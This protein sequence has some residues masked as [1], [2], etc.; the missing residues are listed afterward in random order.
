MKVDR[1]VLKTEH[2][3]EE[4]LLQLMQGK[5]IDQ[6]TTTEVCRTASINRNTFYAHYSTPTSLLDHIVEQFI[7]ILV[8][9]I[10]DAV[11]YNNNTELVEHILNDLL[12][13]QALASVILSDD[14]DPVY[15]NR[16]ISAIRGPLISYWTQSGTSIS[17]NE[18]STL[19]T[20][21]SFGANQL[22]RDWVADNFDTPTSKLA[23][24]IGNYVDTLLGIQNRS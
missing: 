15:L 23:I 7:E 19:F 2:T 11:G 4:S 14:S 16:V 9:T 10:H 3:L 17:E 21:C 12:E 22:I 1:R 8:D 18:L 6:I 13:H 20:F 5:S 24:V